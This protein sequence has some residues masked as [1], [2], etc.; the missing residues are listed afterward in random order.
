MTEIKHETFGSNDAQEMLNKAF[1]E[2][3][4]PIIEE[5]PSPLPSYNQTVITLDLRKLVEL[6]KVQDIIQ[7][8]D[9]HFELATLS[10]SQQAKAYK[11]IQNGED[12]EAFFKLRRVIVAFSLISING[13][14]VE[15]IDMGEKTDSE[16]RLSLVESFQGNVVDKLYEFY[17]SI[18]NRSQKE[19]DPEQVKN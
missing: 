10:D 9:F 18:L 13:Q 3:A 17:E 5:A 4:K 1:L 11:I 15:E 7:I 2:K 12:S 16:K 6:G 14:L 19:I 8:G